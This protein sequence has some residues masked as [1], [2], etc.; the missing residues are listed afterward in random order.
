MINN[1]TESNQFI[2]EVTVEVI[3][4]I[5]VAVIVEINVEVTVEA[6][7]KSMIPTTSLSVTTLRS[8]K[9][10]V[11]FHRIVTTKGVGE[12]IVLLLYVDWDHS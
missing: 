6:A 10:N 3:V 8:T 1:L 4:E 9:L 2:A 5:N 12:F 11:F 7:I